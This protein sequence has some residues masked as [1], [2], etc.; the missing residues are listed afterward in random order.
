MSLPAHAP[1]SSTD[2]EVIESAVM[3]TER[4][5]WFLTEYAERNRNADTKLVLDAIQKLQRTVLGA[6]LVQPAAPAQTITDSDANIE[7]TRRELTGIDAASK[8][9]GDLAAELAS[10]VEASAEA[11]NGVL[12]DAE[13]IQEIS[14][15][16]REQGTAASVCDQLDGLAAHITTAC[17]FQDLTGQRIARVRA[18]H[19][20]LIDRVQGL[21]RL[22]QAEAPASQAKPVPAPLMNGPAR[23]GDGLE[24]DQVDELLAID[25]D[26]DV[27]WDDT[28]PTQA[29]AKPVAIN[30]E[31]TLPTGAAPVQTF[32]GRA[33]T[34]AD[35][36]QLNAGERVA[37]LL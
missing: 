35:I 24:Q 15:T 19:Q 28:S 32:P 25:K 26:H 14:W 30:G 13:R 34:R 11:I 1:L 18:A 17:A 22:W 33:L 2:Y 36:E 4:G 5:R 10:I 23:K 7:R 20:L 8:R 6:E 27:F 29:A 12:A 31:R 9:D 37:L 21:V 3:E 16:M